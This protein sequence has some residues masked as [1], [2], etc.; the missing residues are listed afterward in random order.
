MIQ[1][2]KIL[3]QLQILWGV[4]AIVA[5]IT[6]C[7]QVLVTDGRIASE[8][9]ESA[10]SLEG[11]YHGR[12]EGVAGEL[13]FA[14]VGDKPTLLYRNKD[15]RDILNS[16]CGASIG[17]LKSV[18]VQVVSQPTGPQAAMG[19]AEFAFDPGMCGGEIQGRTLDVTFIKT[20]RGP[21]V[22]L[23]LLHHQETVMNCRDQDLPRC[24][25]EVVDHSLLGKFYQSPRFFN[26][27]I[28]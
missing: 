14:M 6:G 7:K 2:K 15:G 18:V 24:Q 17:P 3:S 13:K 1:M 5:L 8:N 9:I 4:L 22:K 20:K 27:A 12:F 26:S 23:S 28:Q 21:L 25:T 10:K 19:R 16:D 11:I